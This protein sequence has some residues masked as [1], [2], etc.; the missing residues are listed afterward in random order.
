MELIDLKIE[1]LK[2]TNGG[3]EFSEGFVRLVGY[4]LSSMDNSLRNCNL[5]VTT[6]I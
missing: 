6:R 3:S 2:K 1:E 5:Y 4:L